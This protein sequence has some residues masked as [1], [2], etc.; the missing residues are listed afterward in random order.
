MATTT[1]A[2]QEDTHFMLSSLKEEYGASN[3]DETL[4]EMIAKIKKPMKS[5]RGAFP[6]MPEFRRED[7]ID[8]FS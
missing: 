1:I 6:G 7:Q 2:I 3:F 5:M 8:R 4:K